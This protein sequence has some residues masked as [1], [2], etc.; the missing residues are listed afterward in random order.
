MDTI[1]KIEDKIKDVFEKDKVITVIKGLLL[2]LLMTTS[3]LFGR[4]SMD[5]T[6]K[7][8]KEQA[9]SIQVYL[10][11]GELYTKENADTLSPLSAYVLGTLENTQNIVEPTAKERISQISAA[12]ESETLN[13]GMVYGS[14]SGKL[15]YT[16]GC[17]AGNR[18]KPENRVFFDD[19]LAAQEEGYTKSKQCK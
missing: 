1:T 2:I 12:S 15:Y 6:D 4:L 10:P 19:E 14:K 5:N 13:S 9:S 7:N 8:K 3:F 16:I 11:S 17:T 18:I